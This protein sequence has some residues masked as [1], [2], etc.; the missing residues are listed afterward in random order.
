[1]WVSLKC[2]TVED[3]DLHKHGWLGSFGGYYIIRKTHAKPWSISCRAF[4]PKDLPV[5]FLR[6]ILD[7]TRVLHEGTI[8]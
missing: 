7:K 3:W 4:I 8:L 5:Y 6:K 2:Y 1:M